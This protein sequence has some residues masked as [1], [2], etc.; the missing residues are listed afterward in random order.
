MLKD[1]CYNKKQSPCS[2]SIS[3]LLCS[4]LSVHFAYYI[5][6]IDLIVRLHM[7][8]RRIDETKFQ[9][10]LEVEDL[11]DNNITLDDFFRNDTD[12]IHSLLSVVME[13]AEKCIGIE[14]QGGIMSLQLSPQP[15]HTLL[16]T[17]SSG[18]E[19]FGDMLRQASEQVSKAFTKPIYNNQSNVIKNNPL[20]EMNLAAKAKP[21]KPICHQQD[22][23][24][25]FA[26]DCFGNFVGSQN[27][28]AKFENLEYAEYCCQSIKKTWGIKNMLYK[29][30]S[31]NSVYLILERGRCSETRFERL[32]NEMMEYS[33]F[34]PYTLEKMGYIKEHF[35]LLIAEN[36][37][38][39]IKRYCEC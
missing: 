14:P 3:K 15:D 9:C 27:A 10:L 20:E 33:V 32:M 2:Y 5:G 13:E 23:T 8:F 22:E 21:F 6:R 30:C 17:V 34:I 16:L 4:W 31:D 18:A 36:A 39:T 19:D 38:N 25:S 26:V 1:I 29:D 35:N 37:V 11:E 12:K 24:E 7:E 28:I